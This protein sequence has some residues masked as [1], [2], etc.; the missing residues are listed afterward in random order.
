MADLKILSQIVFS[1]NLKYKFFV[2]FPKHLTFFVHIF[3]S[4]FQLVPKWNKSRDV[5]L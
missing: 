3:F 2:L 5:G 1:L 4:N